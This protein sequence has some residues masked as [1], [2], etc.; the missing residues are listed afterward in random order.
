VISGIFGQPI[1]RGLS[2]LSVSI[3]QGDTLACA[4]AF[5]EEHPMAI[6]IESLSTNKISLMATELTQV[7]RLLG[8]EYV[9]KG[10]RYTSIWTAKEAL[11]KILRTGMM[12]PFS[13]FAV[14]SLDKDVNK[15]PLAE[16]GKSERFVG[17]YLHFSQY[18]F[19]TWVR[20]DAAMTIAMPRRTKLCGRSNSITIK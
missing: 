20:D 10:I 3:S 9:E 2:G 17:Q 13:L 15:D 4:I 12:T 19:Q 18:R 1:V 5:P 7:E 8:S 6:D 14:E 11:S 16:W